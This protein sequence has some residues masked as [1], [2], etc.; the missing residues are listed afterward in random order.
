MSS[1][2]ARVGKA[3]PNQWAGKDNP[4]CVQISQDGLIWWTIDRYDDL[5]EAKQR[6]VEVL[7][8]MDSD[9]KISISHIYWSKKLL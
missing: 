5:E 6:A 9:L 4:F 8:R 3:I 7:D 2:R 1:I